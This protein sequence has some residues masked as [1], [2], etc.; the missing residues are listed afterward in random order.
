MSP[1]VL[2]TTF[3]YGFILRWLA[4]NACCQ[5]SWRSCARRSRRN[6]QFGVKQC[7]TY[8]GERGERLRHGTSGMVLVV[9]LPQHAIAVI[10]FDDMLEV[11]MSGEVLEQPHG[12][13]A[14]EGGCPDV[15]GGC[16]NACWSACS[17]NC[18]FGGGV[19]EAPGGGDRNFY[20]DIRSRKWLLQ[21]GKHIYVE[22][23]HKHWISEGTSEF[24]GEMTLRY[25]F[26]S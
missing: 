5:R 22:V 14:A 16:W 18:C 23:I 17:W 9:M 1:R 15:S 20:F 8:R 19:S 25:W 21:Q 24:W 13:H 6:Q 2:C 11:S 7:E 4:H 12:Q 3:F 10:G 26:G